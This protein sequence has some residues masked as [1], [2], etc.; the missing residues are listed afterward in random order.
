MT[1]VLGAADDPAVPPLE[2]VVAQTVARG[3]PPASA[4]VVEDQAGQSWLRELA[5]LHGEVRARSV[6]AARSDSG[7]AQA[8]ALGLGGAVWLPPATASM[9]TAFAAAHEFVGL[10]PPGEER[11]CPSNVSLVLRLPGPHSVAALRETVLWRSQ[12]GM[13]SVVQRLLGLTERIGASAALLPGPAVLVAQ[14]SESDLRHAWELD[15]AVCEPELHVR[16]L[17]SEMDAEDG[18]AHLLDVAG[19]LVAVDPSSRT[20][21]CAV[22]PVYAVPSGV[23]VGG[24]T[25]GARPDRAPGWCAVPVV[26]PGVVSELEWE[27]TIDGLRIPEV[28]SSQQIDRAAAAGARAVRVPGWVAADLAKG[29]PAELLLQALAEEAARKRLDLW[30][31]NVGSAALTEVLAL[32]GSLWIDG[33]GTPSEDTWT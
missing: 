2:R 33:P 17:T 26:S 32:P 30:I 9:E 5:R 21:P 20:R 7:L 8:V 28:L 14:T 18:I 4:V 15:A 19:G 16:S 12:L 31:S 13:R 3:A 11:S 25:M 29:R 1:R 27:V 22:F 6:V 10:C 24:W 23:R